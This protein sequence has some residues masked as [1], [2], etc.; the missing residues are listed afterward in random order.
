M[1]RVNQG[2]QS[3]LLWLSSRARRRHWQCQ[4]FSSNR[5]WHHARL[6][7][8]IEL[9]QLTANSTVRAS[10]VG[11]RGCCPPETC[12]HTNTKTFMQCS[13]CPCVHTCLHT[14][15]ATQGGGPTLCHSFEGSGHGAPE[16]TSAPGTRPAKV[17]WGLPAVAAGTARRTG[18]G[19]HRSRCSFSISACVGRRPHHGT[20]QMWPAGCA[21]PCDEM[22]KCLKTSTM[23]RFGCFCIESL[24][25]MC[26]GGG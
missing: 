7:A 18:R 1:T 10:F 17:S 3:W 4:G 5:T 6:T 21:S 2:L 14:R 22:N 19:N 8:S 13:I 23:F 12:T 20:I 15:S 11:L 9:M 16:E 25:V 24:R 26:C